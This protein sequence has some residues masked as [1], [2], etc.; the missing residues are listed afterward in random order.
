[1]GKIQEGREYYLRAIEAAN[2]H[3]NLALKILAQ[4]Y[5]ARE[6]VRSGLKDSTKRFAVAKTHAE[7]LK[8]TNLPAVADH[9]ERELLERQQTPLANVSLLS[10]ETEPLRL[11]M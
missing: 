6:E 7:K 10:S 8:T 9:L 5:L 11:K 3:D 1:M 4:L 2:R